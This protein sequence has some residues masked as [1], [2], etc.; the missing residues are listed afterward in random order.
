[1]EG[2]IPERKMISYEIKDDALCPR[3]AW[4]GWRRRYRYDASA[5]A[6]QNRN[7]V[8]P[9]RVAAGDAGPGHG[10]S[11]RPEVGLSVDAARDQR[12]DLPGGAHR[13]EQAD[14]RNDIYVPLCY[15]AA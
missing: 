7:A 4:H 14:F 1:M 12:C 15:D 3:G 2:Q 6:A 10:L 11:S 9:Q 8:C 5:N 13:W